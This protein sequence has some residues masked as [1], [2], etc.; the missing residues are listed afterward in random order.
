MYQELFEIICFFAPFTPN[1]F[2]KD[3][4]FLQKYGFDT[5]HDGV[6]NE[7]GV[8]SE[9]KIYEECEFSVE[10]EEEVADGGEAGEEDYACDTNCDGRTSR[11]VKISCFKIL[12]L[13]QFQGIFANNSI[14]WKSFFEKKLGISIA[15]DSKIKVPTGDSFFGSYFT[16]KDFI[17]SIKWF[18][19]LDDAVFLNWFHAKAFYQ[20][21]EIFQYY[22]T[23]DSWDSYL[24]NRF[25]NYQRHEQCI[26][27]LETRFPYTMPVISRKIIGERSK[28]FINETITRVV[29]E[30]TSSIYQSELSDLG[31]KEEIKNMK[32]LVHDNFFSV[33]LP[34]LQ[35]G[36]EL[37]EFLK[38]TEK[39]DSLVEIVLKGETFLKNKLNLSSS[40]EYATGKLL[41]KL[42]FPTFC[43]YLGLQFII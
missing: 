34:K 36:L 23:I 29:E 15:K 26:G 33:L 27:F 5:N 41:K 7:E 6:I 12:T 28:N 30:L 8:L 3:H 9:E 21:R 22:S 32:D 20:H 37:N 1:F 35:P 31:K 18:D 40:E 43:E 2:I 14:N 42:F 19:L 39:T 16:L 25:R 13:D 10:N 11:D 38:N 4:A 24:N 17:K